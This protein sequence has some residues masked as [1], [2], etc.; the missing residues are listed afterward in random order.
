V[1][2]EGEEPLRIANIAGRAKLLVG[3]GQVDIEA[4]SSGRFGADPAA[5]FERM[6]ELRAFAGS[7]TQADEAWD[8]VTAGPPSP[9]PRQVFAI[10]LNYAD[11]AAESGVDAPSDPLVFAKY[12]TSLSGPISAV[13]LPAG[14]VDWEVEV[15]AVIGATAHNVSSSVGWDY[16]AG[17]TA[18]QDLS[19]RQLQLS[20]LPAP[21]FGLAKSFP[22]FSPTGP[23][24]VSPEEFDRPDDL[25]LGCDING[26]EVQKGRSSDM[27][28][29]IPELVAYL[30]RI[31][32]L[33]PG[34]LI[35]TGTP[36]GVGMGRTPTRFLQ[37]GDRLHSWIEGIGELEQTFTRPVSSND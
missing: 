27:I 17:L 5:L 11:H 10:A 7:V 24:L 4:A 19:E 33:L 13:A 21:Q 37:E 36:P 1:L 6:G 9:A 18:G 3:S 23:V 20:G 12:V 25:G 31:V 35:F 34:D 22:G 15:V 29:S 30:S 2:E 8:P 14:L 28:F 26:E 32:T 16:V